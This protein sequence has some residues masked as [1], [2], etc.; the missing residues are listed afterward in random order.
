[1]SLFKHLQELKVEAL[2][3][4]DSFTFTKLGVVLAEAVQV[5][6]KKEKRDPTDE[7][8]IGIVKKGLEGIAEML[9]HVKDTVQ[10]SELIAE[11]DLLMKFM[12]TQLSE[13]EIKVIIENAALDH[14]GKIMAVFKNNYAG[15]YDGKLVSKLAAEFLS[16]QS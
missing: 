2:K 5:A 16:K 11:R 8:V 13:T 1:M 3:R 10:W 12:P 14:V 15:K 4:G 9:Q 6:T 7:E